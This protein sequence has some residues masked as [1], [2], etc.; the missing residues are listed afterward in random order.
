MSIIELKNISLTL[1]KQ[2]NILSNINYQIKPHDFIIL[3]GGNGS[4]KSSLLKLLYGQYQ[5]S[6]GSITLLN[7]P[8]QDYT[9]KQLNQQIAT[10]TQDTNDAFF[11]SLTLYENYLVMLGKNAPR[12]HQKEAL[13]KA[14]KD[15]NPNLAKK[16]HCTLD[17]FSG[18]EKQA[19][20]LAFCVFK[21]PK[22]LLLDEHTSA[23]D[24][25]TSKQI[26]ALTANV[27]RASNMTCILTTH[28][29]DIARLYGSRALILKDGEIHKTIESTEK[30]SITKETLFKMYA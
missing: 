26:M 11:N 13:K 9:H 24:P 23:L 25:K 4:G 6:A 15:F 16:L 5:A 12:H 2:K 18:G 3:L 27:V 10:L 30:Q 28:D 14:L 1:N 19:L 7:R 29:L 21:R 22:L 20:A 8:L 17:Q